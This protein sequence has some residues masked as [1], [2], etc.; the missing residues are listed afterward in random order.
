MKI[1]KKK[2]VKDS[3]SRHQIRTPWGD[4]IPK[5]D[6]F[7][8]LYLILLYGVIY[9]L[10]FQVFEV[11]RKGED[12][13][14]EWIQFSCYFFS[15]LLSTYILWRDRKSCS[16]INWMIWLLM[17]IFYLY[18]AGEEISWGERIINTGIDSIRVIN[19]QGETNLHNMK[20]VQ[21]Y[22]HF[23][24]ISSGLFFGWFSWKIWPSITA[25]PSLKY[26][27]YF[28]FVALF[29]TY[30]DLSWITLGERIRNDQEA[31]EILMAIGFF[32]HCW[33]FVFNKKSI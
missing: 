10:P 28:L 4:L 29:Y 14:S 3:E 16:S 11:W 25:F 21:N 19:N 30:W 1:S 13:P 7:P 2:L 23:S 22:L 17:T 18:I 31:I 15:F 24:F 32:K 26:S 27:L 5:V 12:G 9:F 6:L 8:V 20:F 33:E